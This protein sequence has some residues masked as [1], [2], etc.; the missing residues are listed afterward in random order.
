MSLRLRLLA[1]TSAGILGGAFSAN[2][3]ARPLCAVFRSSRH[4]SA[5]I[6]LRPALRHT[7][8]VATAH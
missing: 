4:R 3:V 8:T 1:L 2:L 6:A 5:H 7:T